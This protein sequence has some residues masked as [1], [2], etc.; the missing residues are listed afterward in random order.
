MPVVK[1]LYEQ[2]KGMFSVSSWSEGKSSNLSSEQKS[3]INA[4]LTYYGDKTSQLLQPSLVFSLG[5]K[6]II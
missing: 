4:V 2:H 3:T 1:E 6:T 5:R